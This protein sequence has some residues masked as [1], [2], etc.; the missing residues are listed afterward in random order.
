[1]GTTELTAEIFMDYLKE[2]Q[3]QFTAMKYDIFNNNCNHFTNVCSEF[4][5]G[6]PIPEMYYNQANEFKNTPIGQM[7]QGFN[8]NPNNNNDSYDLSYN[9]FA[10]NIYT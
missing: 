5:L 7:L 4:L 3:P 8:V 1:M 2:I 9:G 10:S 6:E